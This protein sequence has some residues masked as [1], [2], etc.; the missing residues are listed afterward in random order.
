MVRWSFSISRPRTRELGCFFYSLWGY[1]SLPFLLI[2]PRS[3]AALSNVSL[4]IAAGERIAI[5]GASGSGKTSFIM[6]LLKMME[7]RNGQV[8]I[9]DVDIARLDGPELRSRLNVIPQSPF[10]MPGTLNLNLDPA[11]RLSNLA[12]QEAIEQ[13][14]PDLWGKLLRTGDLDAEFAMSE[15]SHGERQLLCLARALLARSNLVI[16]DE[17]TA[18][19]M[20]R[21]RPSSNRLPRPSSRKRLLFPSF[22][23]IPNTPR[24]IPVSQEGLST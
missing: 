11:N 16:L 22:A 7:I 10:F 2:R 5:C 15:W 3:A 9:G 4:S 19:L 17:A 21:R 12:T 13:V 18:A 1:P 23:G 24:A 20:G 14:S 8:L 6:T